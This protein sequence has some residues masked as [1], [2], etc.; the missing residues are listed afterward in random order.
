M[1]IL[2]RSNTCSIVAALLSMMLYPSR[3]YWVRV[4]SHVSQR[5]LK[6]A[7]QDSR[8]GKCPGLQQQQP[9]L[10]SSPSVIASTSLCWQYVPW[11]WEKESVLPVIGRGGNKG[12]LASSHSKYVWK[13]YVYEKTSYGNKLDVLSEPCAAANKGLYITHLLLSL[14]TTTIKA[15]RAWS[16]VLALMGSE[17][18]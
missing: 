11:Q 4:I 16:N 17:L 1:R 15:K 12:H 10:S 5:R 6:A 7:L 8:W 13:L 9:S 14:L 3:M 18:S 2:R